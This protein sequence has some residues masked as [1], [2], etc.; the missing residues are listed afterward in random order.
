M[1]YDSQEFERW[2]MSSSIRLTVYCD[3][4]VQINS[5]GFGLCLPSSPSVNFV[6]LEYQ[7]VQALKH[8][9]LWL[10]IEVMTRLKLFM[11]RDIRTVFDKESDKSWRRRGVS[12]Q[13]IQ[14]L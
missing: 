4:C 6:D 14:W 9:L 10:F 13:D 12:L 7:V 1:V 3:P 11:M 8:S 2:K 5:I